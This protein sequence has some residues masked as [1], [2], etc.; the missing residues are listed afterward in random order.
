MVRDSADTYTFGFGAVDEQVRKTTE[1][2]QPS[3]ARSA[4]AEPRI[5]RN[6]SCRPSEFSQERDGY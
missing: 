1:R 5:R 3:R 6:D 2:K 4:R